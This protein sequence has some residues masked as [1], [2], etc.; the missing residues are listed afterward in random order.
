M[1]HVN[2]MRVLRRAPHGPGAL[3]VVGMVLS[4]LTCAFH[5]G[6]ACAAA[7]AMPG[8]GHRVAAVRH[9]RCGQPGAHHDCCGGAHSD[10]RHGSLCCSTWASAPARPSLPVP[11]A[12]PLAFSAVGS[13]LEPDATVP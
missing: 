3:L 10:R 6:A 13:W 1:L 2:L 11:P 7:N 5:G 8:E 4:T 9:D 12:V